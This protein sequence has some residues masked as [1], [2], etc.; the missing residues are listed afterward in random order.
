MFLTGRVRVASVD[1]G[2]NPPGEI[3]LKDSR[4]KADPAVA[5]CRVVAISPDGGPPIDLKNPWLA[6]I[7]S[8]L[9]PGLGQIYQ[10]RSFKGGL[11]MGTILGTFLAGLFMGGGKV[12]YAS[13]R[14][15]EVR[16]PYVCQAAAG[17]VAMPAVIQS[18]G[19]QGSSRE[20][21]LGTFMAPPLGPGQFVSVRYADQLAATDPDI[22]P[23]D[24]FDKPP[25]RQFKGDEL[26]LW[27][28]RL[29]RWFEIGTLYTMLAGMLN[30]LVVYDALSGPLGM[31]TDEDRRKGANGK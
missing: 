31:P 2:V 15:G 18:M 8:W 25:L 1:G 5:G 14:P 6:A 17:L 10:G 23:D 27:H 21:P 28:R 13:W 24:F 29:G 30:I 7:L 19:L 4:A 11:F 12:V 26:S 16:W 22:A 9:L 20:P 3:A